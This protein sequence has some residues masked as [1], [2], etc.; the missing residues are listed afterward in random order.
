MAQEAPLSLFLTCTG[1]DVT[2]EQTGTKVEAPS[3]GARQ[4]AAMAKLPPPTVTTSPEYGYVRVPGRLSIAIEGGVVRVRPSSGSS[5]TFRK[6]ADGWYELGD[7][8]ITDTE[9][10]GKASWGFPS[11]LGLTIDRRSG[12]VSFGPFRGG[13]EKTADRPDARKF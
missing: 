1:Q 11:K 8:A 13:C 6:S 3:L 12:D 9:I 5:P 2:Y 7:V 4:H 10:R